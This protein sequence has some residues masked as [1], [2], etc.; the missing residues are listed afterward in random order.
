MLASAAIVGIITALCF[1]FRG[2]GFALMQGLF[3]SVGT[4]LGLWLV[5]GSEQSTTDQVFSSLLSF[6]E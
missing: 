6:R 4:Y 2:P 3:A 1:S 5:D